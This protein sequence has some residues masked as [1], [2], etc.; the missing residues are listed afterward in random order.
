MLVSQ[1]INSWQVVDNF[2]CFFFSFEITVRFL[3]YKHRSDALKE[4]GFWWDE[5]VEGAVRECKDR[6]MIEGEM[7]CM[8]IQFTW[9]YFR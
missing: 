4:P 2:F 1:E 9:S 8:M 5:D 3:A 6:E 7:R